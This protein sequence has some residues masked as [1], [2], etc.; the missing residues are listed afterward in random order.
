VIDEGSMSS[1]LTMAWNRLSS[2]GFS[3]CRDHSSKNMAV[4]SY[5]LRKGL[6]HGFGTGAIT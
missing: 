6:V 5:G 2:E 4:W 1:R 3:E